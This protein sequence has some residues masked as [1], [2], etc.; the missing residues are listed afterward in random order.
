M[1]EKWVQVWGQAHSALSHFY[2]P[3]CAKT[4]RTVISSAISGSQLRLELCNNPGKNPVEIGGVTVAKCDE[5]GTFIDGNFTVVTVNSKESFVIGKNEMVVTDPVNFN[6]NAGEY[7]CISIYV[8][9]GDLCSGNL[10]D[11]VNLITIKG[12][13]TKNP[14][15]ENQ[16]RIRD[17]VRKIAS[18][19]LRMCFHKPIP[20]LNTVELLNNDGASAI[21][22]FGDSISQQGF[23]TNA[24]EKR[25]RERYFGRYAVINR[26]IMGNRVLRDFS[27]RFPCPGLFGISGIKRFDRDVLRF[28]D[29]E[30]VVFVLGINDFIQ[31]GTLMAPK[32]EKP[33]PEKVFNAVKNIAQKVHE[34]GKKIIVL[35]LLHFGYCVDSRPEKEQ[36]AL[37]YNKLLEKNKDLFDG[38]YDQASLCIDENKPNCTRLDLLGKDKLHPNFEG[39]QIVANNFDLSLFGIVNDN[40]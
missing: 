3:S 37:E 30:Y 13:Y 22:V 40:E 17:S 23:W 11:N 29:A 35:N 32:S 24:F 19:V 38:F 12:D 31:Y 26:S 2:Y 8:V 28:P 18:S 14:Y 1:S 20:L 27:T 34:K 10:I 7:F 6:I 33:T 5:K 9:K 39:G 25:I 15:A 16:P 21:V 4:Y 36:M